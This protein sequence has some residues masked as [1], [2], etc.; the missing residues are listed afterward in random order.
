[1]RI[2]HAAVQR[3][4]RDAIFEVLRDADIDFVVT[5]E[6]REGDLL[7]LFPLPTPAVESVLGELRDAGLDDSF[8]LI[9]SGETANTTNFRRLEERF[10]E[11]EEQDDSIA[12]E[13]VRSKALDMNP[14]RRTYYSM[15][16][17]SVIVATV[18]LILDAPTVVVGSMVIAPQVSSALVTSV[19]LTFSD[20][21]LL[22]NGLRTQLLGLAF[23][24]LAAAAFGWVLKSA[25]I[26]PPVMDLTTVSQISTRTSPGFLALVLGVCS[27]AAGGFGLATDLPVSLVGVAVAAALIPAAAAAGIGLAW[28][29]PTIVVGGV[30]L[31][32]L[33]VLAI[34]LAGAGAL[35]FLGYRPV[36]W[37][38]RSP[39]AALRGGALNAMVAAL[40][41]AAVV[42]GV[43]A[44]PVASHTAVENDTNEAVETVL[45][46]P[47]YDSVTLLS[48]TLEFGGVVGD[49]PEAVTVRVT[50]PADR[51]YPALAR[52]LAERISA[53]TD[54][55]V[56]VTVEFV[57]QDGAASTDAGGTGDRLRSPPRPTVSG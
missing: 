28:W 20:R 45:D 32:V 57:E 25:E 27:G 52:R 38:E 11:G 6:E 33:N 49:S 37:R 44:L 30:V 41:V 43:V 2:V 40:V 36:A 9:G 24:V 47:A 17:L 4:D 39:A 3:D 8:V 10:V 18:G 51:A 12:P 23:A 16:L 50:R 42:V 22:Q 26:A 15:T 54:L 13:E 14:G 48:V 5:E 1:M 53:R 21:R 19:G 35:W 31:L 29:Y 46:Q 34:T 55:P 56:V 7:V